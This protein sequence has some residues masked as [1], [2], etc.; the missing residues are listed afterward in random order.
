VTVSPLMLVTV[1]WDRTLLAMFDRD[2]N[3]DVSG[4]TL[5]QPRMKQAE[6][7]SHRARKSP[8]GDPRGTRSFAVRSRPWSHLSCAQLRLPRGVTTTFHYLRRSYNGE[9]R[10][11]R[12]RLDIMARAG[13]AGVQS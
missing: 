3:R 9:V 13:K 8:L 2:G 10:Q 4:M 11:Y 5:P 6:E 7:R 1:G 12:M